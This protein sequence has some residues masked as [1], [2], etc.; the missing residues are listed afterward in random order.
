[1][2]TFIPIYFLAPMA[3]HSNSGSARFKIGC[4]FF[5]LYIPGAREY[6]PRLHIHRQFFTL[7]HDKTPRTW[8]HAKSI[9]AKWCLHFYWDY[10]AIYLFILSALRLRFH[11]QTR[12]ISVLLLIQPDLFGSSLPSTMMKAIFPKDIPSS[13]TFMGVGGAMSEVAHTVTRTMV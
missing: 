10:L 7:L 5:L 9:I 11:I 2:I 12:H 6:W 3:K 1:M 4:P 8:K 13:T